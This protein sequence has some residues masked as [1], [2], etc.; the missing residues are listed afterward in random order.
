MCTKKYTLHFLHTQHKEIYLY[1]LLKL[2]IN[3]FEILLL[4]ITI[5]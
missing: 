2:H 5:F 3:I 1:Y 4:Y